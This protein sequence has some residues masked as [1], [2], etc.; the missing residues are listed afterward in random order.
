MNILD[1]TRFYL[2]SK[3]RREK[4]TYIILFWKFEGK[5]K[6]KRKTNLLYYSS[7]GYGNEK[8]GLRQDLTF[9]IILEKILKPKEKQTFFYLDMEEK[10]S[11]VK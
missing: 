8:V 4:K 5:K 3:L 2:P 1:L 10:Q 7:E 6:T 9:D 11:A